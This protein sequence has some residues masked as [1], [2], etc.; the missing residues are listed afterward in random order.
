M[1]T[2]ISQNNKRIAKNTLVLYFRTFVTMIVGLY[3]SRVMLQAL[4]VD[5][6]GINN[7]VGGIVAMSG[8]L[9]NSLSKSCSRYIT[10]A[11][12]IGNL[13]NSRNVYSTVVNVQL[14]M[15]IIVTVVLELIG[16]WF[17]NTTADIP[18]GRMQAA[19]W[20]MH[21]SVLVCAIGLLSVPYNST[22]VAH[23]RMTVYAYMS[24]VDV[25]LKLANCFAVL[26]Y[27]GDKLILF[28]IL[29]VIEGVAIWFFYGWYCSRQFDE[30]KYNF[31]LDKALLKEMSGFTGWNMLGSTAALFNDHGVNMLI[32]VFFGVTYNAARGIAITVNSCVQSF[33][34][35][36]GM[37][38][39]PQI[40]KSYAQENYVYCY[41]LTNRGTKFTWLMMY[42]FIVPVCMEAEQLLSLW[43]V[44]VPEYA[45]T[46]LRLVMFESLAIQSG[47]TLVTLIHAEGKVKR[48][49]IEVFFTVGLIFPLVWLS[50]YLGAPV[51]SCNV[52]FISIYFTLVNIVKFRALLRVTDF[53]LKSF[54]VDVLKPCLL[55]SFLSF[56][57]PLLIGYFWEDSV[58]RFFVM[59][60][61]SVAWTIIICCIFG[62]TKNERSFFID[63]VAHLI[64]L[65]TK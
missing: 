35:N 28:A 7:V 37:A 4:G 3:T 12:G 42:V 18:E 38:F 33:I 11:I 46:F 17:L 21:C 31:Q 22:I 10:Y 45:P 2:D 36:F 54:F 26:Y 43:L 8:L 41:S 60:P 59:S 55:V 24:I 49:Q 63:K 29:G 53:P 19:N 6:Y 27:G 5:N 44:E 65:K 48:Y 52:I 15:V 64:K 39:Q 23:E 25:L 34:A 9:S 14:I 50:Y 61:I 57:L 1:P 47:H 30:V 20:V 13:T 40:T 51:W 16:V 32:N 62:L 56:S 58:L